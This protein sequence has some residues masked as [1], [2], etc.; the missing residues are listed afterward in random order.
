MLSFECGNPLFGFSSNPYDSNRTCGGSSGGEAALLAADGSSIGFG[1][2]VGGSLRIP[3]AYCGNFALKPCYGRFASDGIT[4]S[5]PGF[6]SI[7]S[8]LGPMARSIED[9]ELATRIVINASVELARTL[10]LIP[11]PFREITLPKKLKFGYYFTDGFVKASPACC[12]AING[13]V[14]ALR[15]EGHECVEFDPPSRKVSILVLF[16]SNR[17]NLFFWICLFFLS[18]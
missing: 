15:R 14:E 8:T 13:T 9:L 10:P 4:S 2:D 12:R 7:K 17:S 3:S 18:F 6:D 1:S 11:L 16:F 5:N